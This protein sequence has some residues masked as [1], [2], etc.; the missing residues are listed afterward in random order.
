MRWGRQEHSVASVR[1]MLRALIKQLQDESVA[2][3]R[4][5]GEDVVG[6]DGHRANVLRVA[7]VFSNR[8]STQRGL[9][10]SSAI[11]WRAAVTLVQQNP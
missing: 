10:M 4:A 6:G 8:V 3:I 7:V 2:P 11:H 9:S 1:A 5:P